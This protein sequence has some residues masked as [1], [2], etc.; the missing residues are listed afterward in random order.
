[1]EWSALT[2]ELIVA[3]AK[4]IWSPAHTTMLCV[5]RSW[6]VPLKANEQQ[7]WEAAT[8]AAFPLA[9]RMLAEQPR[10]SIC[11][12]DV[13]RTHAVLRDGQRVVKPK[14][15]TLDQYLFTF[16][17]TH[18]SG[19]KISRTQ[20]VA[21]EDNVNAGTDIGPLW[22]G[23]SP[24]E[25]LGGPRT[26]QEASA[27]Y[28]ATTAQQPQWVQDFTIDL[29]VSPVG[30]PNNIVHV[31]AECNN[32]GVSG[33]TEEGG[34]VWDYTLI[35][36]QQ[37]PLLGRANAQ[38]ELRWPKGIVTIFWFLDPAGS[39]DQIESLSELLAHFELGFSPLRMKPKNLG[40]NQFWEVAELSDP[41]A[42]F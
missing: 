9:T 12:K 30:H 10:E 13:Y 32:L 28:D 18:V 2:P 15:R 8:S 40:F 24:P 38:V 41:W 26:Y 39:G 20:R 21:W 23:D 42:T 11:F 14:L 1:M 6:R 3:V 25:W 22:E 5:C 19:Q 4:M 27:E 16:E 34:G 17:L 7:L 29:F 35:G 37:E 33:A 31:L 36:G